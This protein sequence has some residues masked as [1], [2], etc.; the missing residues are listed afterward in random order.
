M[1]YWYNQQSTENNI[2]QR[3][4]K[5]LIKFLKLSKEE[6]RTGKTKCE[7]CIGKKA[8]KIKKILKG[9]TNVLV[10]IAGIAVFVATRGRKGKF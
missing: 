3:R 7:N 1:Q 9:T 10:G 2:N 6:V 4:K 8:S 5:F